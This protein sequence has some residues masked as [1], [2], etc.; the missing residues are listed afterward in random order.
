MTDEDLKGD[1]YMNNPSDKKEE[2]KVDLTPN[3]KLVNETA[4]KVEDIFSNAKL[5]PL[6]YRIIMSRLEL[7]L[8][9]FEM[10]LFIEHMAKQMEKDSGTSTVE[11]KGNMFQ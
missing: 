10:R 6:D 3:M 9:D 11:F 7:M 4:D 5:G 2:P 1:A 8:R